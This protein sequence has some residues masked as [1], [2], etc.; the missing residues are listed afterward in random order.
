MHTG[1][2]YAAD[3]AA[4]LSHQHDNGGSLWASCILISAAVMSCV[5][6]ANAASIKIL[7][8]RPAMGKTTAPAT[9]FMSFIQASISLGSTRY[10]LYL[11]CSSILPRQYKYPFSI[12]PISPVR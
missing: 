2:P 3:I 1:H 10:P 7:L 6:C 9:P 8:P 5:F 4:I 11:I 12:L